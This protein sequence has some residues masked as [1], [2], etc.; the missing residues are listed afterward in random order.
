MEGAE[1]AEDAVGAAGAAVALWPHSLS[2]SSEC[3]RRN[4]AQMHRSNRSH[5]LCRSLRRM[6]AAAGTP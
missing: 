1:G 4:T 2:P 3:R 5:V 6:P